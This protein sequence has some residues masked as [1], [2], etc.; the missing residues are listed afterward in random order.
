MDR[1]HAAPQFSQTP[2][3]RVT[4]GSIFF[5]ITIVIAIC[6]YMLF[7]WTALE[8]FYMVVITVFG[9][10]YGEVKPLETT[11]EKLFTIFV[12]LAG[13][14]AA[15]YGVGG[16]VQMVTE[17]EIN[18][19]FEAERQRK[20]ISNLENHIV[21]CGFGY[22]GQILAQKLEDSGQA[23]V[24]LS[25]DPEQLAIAE[26]RSYLTK[27]GD[28][29]DE[30]ILQGLGIRRAKALATV[31]DSDASNVFITLTARELNPDLMILA[32]GEVPS[33]EKKLRLAGANH[34]ILPASVSG[35]R[36]ANL[37]T[38]PPATD[39]FSQSS[40]QEQLN[41]LLQQINVQMI[42]LAIA[43]QSSLVGK[44]VRELE[45]RG[46]GAFIVVALRR[47]Q[48]DFITH[49]SPTLMLTSGDILVVLG[50]EEDIPK[51]ARFYQLFQPK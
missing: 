40:Q 28:P 51:F 26:Q 13:T 29:A 9:V 32:R 43:P 20:S 41:D 39:F 44:T 38:T 10:G 24:V 46:K 25:I 47:F 27:E 2:F 6:G 21:I 14:S 34:V 5:L 37:I 48:G 45:I 18:R 7:G 49:P 16:F 50:H 23:F 30:L 33:T 22:I 35:A 1:P 15:I 31:L 42:E 36:M 17:G 11:P 3:Q 19:A 12:I 4:T 8:S